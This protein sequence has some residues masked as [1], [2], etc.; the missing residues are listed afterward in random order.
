MQFKVEAFHNPY[1]PPDTRRVDAIVT[2][3]AQDDGT[4]TRGRAGRTSTE[5]LILDVSGSMQG[6]RLISVK[7]AARKAIELLDEDT[8]FFVIAFNHEAGLVYPL[9]RATPTNKHTAAEAVKRL[10]A[11]GSTR[12]S[13]GLALARQEFG[14]AP[15]TIRHAL[16]LTDGKNAPEDEAQLQTALY[17]SEGMFQCDCRGVGTDWQPSQLRAIAQKLLGSAQIIPDPKGLEDDFRATLQNALSRGVGDVRL[18]LWTPKTARVMTCKQMSPD[19]IDLTARGTQIDAQTYEYP[20]GAWGSE[21]RDYY[22]AIEIEPGTPG[23]EMLTCRASIIYSDNGN[24]VK[25]APAMVLATWT[26]DEGLSARIEPQVAHYTGQEELAETIRLGLEARSRGDA[27]EA[28]ARLGRAVQ[29][30][31][32]SGNSETTRRLQ[33]VVDVVDAESGTVRLKAGVHK[34]DEMDLDLMSTRTRR[35]GPPPTA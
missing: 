33:K 12:L 1:L 21:S 32:D 31:H 8:L 2:V 4:M 7:N 25:S 9:T 23:D 24:E 27:R 30:A 3:N 19:I 5:A 17:Q 6:E 26:E 13:S 28:T 18:R 20:T 15:N 29:L 22:A 11:G 35:A 10:V 16:F 34:A 14:K